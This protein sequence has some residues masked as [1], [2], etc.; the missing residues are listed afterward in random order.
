MRWLANIFGV[1]KSK[2]LVV[3][4]QIQEKFSV[5]QSLLDRHN[6]VLKLISRL[7][8]KQQNR[9]I[10][11]IH[12]VW[13]DVVQIQEGVRETIDRMIELGGDSYLQLR[14]RLASIME[15]IEGLVPPSRPVVKDDFIFPF[16]SLDRGRAASVGT[17]NANLGEIRSIIGLPVPDGFAISAWAYLHFIETNQ[18]QD[19]IRALLANVRIR[20]YEDLETVSDDIREMVNFRSVPEDLRTAQEI[21]RP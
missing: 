12:S 19:R 13:D 15:E 10:S 8:E 18:L 17:K 21:C 14:V 4:K 9:E 5:F 7:E 6:H 11:G 1:S 16:N 20:R 2:R 3:L